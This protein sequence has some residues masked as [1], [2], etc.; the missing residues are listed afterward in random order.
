VLLTSLSRSAGLDDSMMQKA[1]GGA[2]RMSLSLP[3]EGAD[4][5]YSRYMA[6]KRMTTATAPAI[7]GIIF[8]RTGVTL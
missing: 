5:K 6:R 2:I 3:D 4:R 1:S 8:F 7:K